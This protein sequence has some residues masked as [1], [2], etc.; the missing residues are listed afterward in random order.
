MAKF[1]YIFLRTLSISLVAAVAAHSQA[2]RGSNQGG[3]DRSKLTFSAPAGMVQVKDAPYSGR[4]VI[5]TPNVP[6]RTLEKTW[7]DSSGR[8]RTEPAANQGSPDLVYI[9]DPAAG[10]SYVLD[11]QTH[12]AHRVA[13]NVILHG[14]EPDIGMTEIR[15]NC[16]RPATE[17]LFTR[18]FSGVSAVGA[19]QTISCPV[20]TYQNNDKPI[21]FIRETWKSIEYNLTFIDKN[22]DP[23]SGVRTT[24]IEDFNPAEPDPALFRVPADYHVVEENATFSIAVPGNQFGGPPPG[25]GPLVVRISGENRGGSTTFQNTFFVV[26]N[27]PWSGT[28]VMQQDQILP[29]GTHLHRNV[30]ATSVSRDS[31]GKTR[32]EHTIAGLTLVEIDD[33]AGYRYIIDD[34]N[35]VVYRVPL[36]ALELQNPEGP[37]GLPLRDP[38]TAFGGPAGRALPNRAAP[39]TEQL[40]TQ[41]ISGAPATGYRVTEG[42]RTTEIW[43]YAPYNLALETK[44][45]SPQGI[46]V[47]RSIENFAPKEPAAVLFELPDKYKIADK[48]GPLTITIP[49][50][51]Q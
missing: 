43:K 2:L 4:T 46:T 44:E 10:F 20:G 11:P 29:D 31:A 17:P 33:P 25:Q 41:T 3:A 30:E 16:D 42:N 5:T 48:T 51:A 26:K 37:D 45:S 18:D 28:R 24:S 13:I 40:G 32:V 36:E 7:R 39:S 27:A 6:S 35:H 14:T 49:V 22:T 50:A 34:W 19:R 12:V 9:D 8:V 47:I 21:E 23:Q 15:Q 38:S 1:A